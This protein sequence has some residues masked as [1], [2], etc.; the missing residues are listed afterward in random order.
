[1]ALLTPTFESAKA[2]I[3][4][5]TL[6]SDTTIS[7]EKGDLLIVSVANNAAA[8]DTS[9]CVWGA[10]AMERRPGLSLNNVGGRRL[11]TYFLRVANTDARTVTASWSTA[12]TN[13][14]MII[15]VIKD[16]V[17][18]DIIASAIQDAS[19]TPTT[20]AT[21]SIVMRDNELALSFMVSDGDRTTDAAGTPSGGFVLGERVGTTGLDFRA[22]YDDL[23]G[24]NPL[25]TVTCSLTNAT[26]RDWT[27]VMV[28]LF[29]PVSQ[30]TQL[31]LYSNQY[32]KL[33]DSTD[34]SKQNAMLLYVHAYYMDSMPVSPSTEWLEGI[35]LTS[36]DYDN[37]LTLLE[38]LDVVSTNTDGEFYPKGFE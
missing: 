1:M 8:G 38:N 29:Q 30:D 4:G 25:A 35:N 33:V 26:S 2:T 15:V 19:T 36:T 27:S 21:N 5:T 32:E 22:Y 16:A 17:R 10:K 11:N 34:A 20:S 23:T 6:A 28:V 14:A 7:C 13:R 3:S 18:R 37:A 9:G 31:V 12:N 24:M